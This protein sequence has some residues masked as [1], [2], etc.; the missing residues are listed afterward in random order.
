ME[1][2]MCEWWSNVNKDPEWLNTTQTLGPHRIASTHGRKI[3]YEQHE[4]GPW[5]VSQ[6]PNLRTLVDR[7]LYI[8]I[9]SWALSGNPQ[10]YT[11]PPLPSAE[12]RIMPYVGIP[13][14]TYFPLDSIYTVGKQ[15]YFTTSPV[16]AILFSQSN[17][18][19]GTMLKTGVEV[20]EL[21]NLHVMK[22]GIYTVK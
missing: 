12:Q 1:A 15:N 6:D 13:R 21:Q 5:A 9:K 18:N 8:A 2:T 20:L 3:K 14:Y 16:V 22:Y 11:E 19:E 4:Q 7:F 17:K 10:W